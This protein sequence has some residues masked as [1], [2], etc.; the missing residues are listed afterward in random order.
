MRHKAYIYNIYIYMIIYVYCVVC[1][2]SLSCFPVSLSS[3]NCCHV[4]AET[5]AVGATGRA[6]CFSSWRRSSSNCSRAR[7]RSWDAG[8]VPGGNF[9][10]LWNICINSMITYV[11][12]TSSH[13]VRIY[14]VYICLYINIYHM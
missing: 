2:M 11:H 12:H 8:V 1:S 10:A 13:H 4:A 7:R 14:V 5:L 3:R 6:R 9:G